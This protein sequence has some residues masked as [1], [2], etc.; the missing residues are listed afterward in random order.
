MAKGQSSRSLPEKETRE[1]LRAIFRGA[2]EGPSTPKKEI[3][4]KR[5]TAYRNRQQNKPDGKS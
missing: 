2:F 1:R 3:P 4:K 5:V